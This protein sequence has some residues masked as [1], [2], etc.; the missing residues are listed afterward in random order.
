VFNEVVVHTVLDVL[1]NIVNKN[2]ITDSR[3]FSMD[4]TSHTVVQRPER[5]MS[6]KDSHEV[7]AM[8]LCERG[9][10]ISVCKQLSAGCFHVPPVLIYPRKSIEVNPSCGS[11]PGIVFRVEDSRVDSVVLCEWKRHLTSP[12][13]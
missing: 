12:Q 7:G 1:V 3:I 11:R 6:Q 9:Q 13:L 10:N 2:N 5:I 4:E 8:L